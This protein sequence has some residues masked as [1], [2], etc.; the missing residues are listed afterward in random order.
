M[1]TRAILAASA[2]LLAA[3]MTTTALAASTARA[4]KDM[5][6]QPSDFPKS[7]AAQAIRPTKPDA[8]SHVVIYR[9]R[10]VSRKRAELTSS[11]TVMP[12][13]R[14][15]KFLYR[16]QRS[17]LILEIQNTLTLPSYG[18]EQVAA[19]LPATDG[20]LVVRKRN[21]VWVLAIGAVTGTPHLTTGEAIAEF[22]RFGPKARKR[23]GAGG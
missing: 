6:L 8:I 4:P 7:A 19:Y 21:T 20:Q 18:D 1:T 16:E 17:G 10:T 2:A 23:V 12:N 9:Y 11:V 14:L 3:T 22:K 5:V 13:A 15:A